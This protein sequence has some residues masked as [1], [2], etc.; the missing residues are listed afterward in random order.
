MINYETKID[1]NR[2]FKEVDLIHN[3][4][5]I[6]LE[7]FIPNPEN[8]LSW[9]EVENAL[10]SYIFYW[11]IFDGFS[12]L[13]LPQEHSKYLPP[14]FSKESLQ[15]HIKEGKTFIIS[16]YSISNS[17][18]KA[19][20][21]EIESLFPVTVDMHVYGSKGNT[22][23]SFPY[24]FDL[25]S[26]FIIQTYGECEWKVYSNFPSTLIQD[27]HPDLNIDKLDKVLHTTLKPGDMLYIP[28]RFYH[29]AFPNQPRLSVSIPCTPG[30]K[31][32]VDKNYYEI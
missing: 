32:R 15:S 24:H 23:S 18:T 21:S 31:G 8:F 10:N 25:P 14:Y 4:Q 19:L 28:S 9:K 29:A 30:V 2:F 17:Y 5:P 27:S 26:N 7:N 11:E 12:K 16:K 22:S 3:D 1:W 6:L 20:C 13:D